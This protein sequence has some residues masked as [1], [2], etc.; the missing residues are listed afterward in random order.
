MLT[1]YRC[2]QL[3]FDFHPESRKRELMWNEKHNDMTYDGDYQPA[4]RQPRIS[5]VEPYDGKVFNDVN[6]DSCVERSKWLA[7]IGF[8]KAAPVP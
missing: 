1:Y 5:V 2:G 4:I 7:S 8:D 3:R 6:Q